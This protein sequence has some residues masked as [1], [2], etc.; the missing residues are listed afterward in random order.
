M[1]GC[2]AFFVYSANVTINFESV[3]INEKGVVRMPFV[4]IQAKAGRTK[5]QKEALAK[6]IINTMEEQGFA[7]RESI[8]VIYEDMAQEDFYSGRDIPKQDK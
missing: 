2:L 3:I 4:R 8:R 5:E 7:S 1:K 6:T